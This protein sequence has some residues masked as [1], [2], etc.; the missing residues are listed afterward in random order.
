MA[1]GSRFKPFLVSADCPRGRFYAA[2]TV[3]F[4]IVALA[5]FF[6]FIFNGR[7]FV[8]VDT[9]DGGD[10]LVQHFNA[11]CYYGMWLRDIARNLLFEHSLVVPMWDMS[12]GYG[13]DVIT[14][15]SYYVIGDP[16]S[17]LSV[18]IPRRFA[19]AGYCALIVLRMY[20]AGVAFCMFCRSRN[21]DTH[22]TLIGSI[23]YVF[24]FYALS[25]GVLHPY[26]LLP[27]IWLPLLLMGV[28]KILDDKSGLQYALVYALAG[29]SNFYF[30]YMLTIIVLLYAIARYAKLYGSVFPVKRLLKHIARMLVYSLLGAGAAAVLLLPSMMGILSA[31][32]VN[33]ENYVP[34]LYG[35]HHYVRG[36][37]A[38]I[39]GGYGSYTYL[40]FTVVGWVSTCLLI[41]RYKQSRDHK[42]LVASFLVLMLFLG[43]PFV[44]HVFNGFG[45]VTN[46]WVWALA[47][48]VAYIVAF[49]VPHLGEITQS[50]RKAILIISAVA[51]L[52]VLAVPDIC[53]EKN[54]LAFGMLFFL[55]A[56]MFYLLDADSAKR[57]MTKLLY[58]IVAVGVASNA[59]YLY[60]P[61]EENYLKNYAQFGQALKMLI[62]ESPGYV[63]EDVSDEELF[64]YDCAGLNVGEVRRNSAMQL[65]LNG[66]AYYFSTTNSAVSAFAR[67]LE[68][69]YSMDQTYNDL[70]RRTVLDRIACVRYM[71]TT[72]DREKYLPLGYEHKALEGKRFNAYEGSN[73]LSFGFATDKV[74]STS[75]FE[76]ANV[77][78]KERLLSTGIVYDGAE[79]N[80]GLGSSRE[81]TLDYKV[82]CG[83]G[84][85]VDDDGNIV[86]DKD[87]STVKLSFGPIEGREL[88]VEFN[89]LD[90]S[91]EGPLSDANAENGGVKETLARFADALRWKEPT[92][93][94][95]GLSD[96]NITT[97][98]QYRTMK[99]NYYCGRDTFIA[100]L[101][102]SADKRSEVTMKFNRAGTYSFDSIFLYAPS[103]AT[104][105]EDIANLNAIHMENVSM[106][107]NGISGSISLP[108]EGVLCMQIPY[109]SGWTARIDGEKAS[110]DQADVMFVGMKV[111]A[112]SH[113]IQ[114][115]Y[116]T[117]YLFEGAAISIVSLV[118]LALATVMCRV[119][120]SR[121]RNHE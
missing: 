71:L 11:F 3:L 48:L 112:G 30:F 85:Y 26:F 113:E 92:S 55:L 78:D 91:C 62:N 102:L 70:D 104:L 25:S 40:G 28:D 76:E 67:E 53:T 119:R 94:D 43:L 13:Q 56:V 63:L 81:P 41:L 121:E 32:R 36:I 75:T 12:I 34:L 47:F 64:R 29:I 105:D 98:V 77:V 50:E 65:D 96:G 80:L 5:V 14:T 38:F 69:N 42:F 20:C 107:P 31:S 18:A 35:L 79:E 7:S 74:V 103:R 117:P 6:P 1:F 97:N 8:F 2:Y 120:G 110:L 72:P 60:S 100:N 37:P 111:P 84:A 89:K 19:E 83:E 17:F 93:V 39:N 59:F 15:L 44:G 116:R 86:I 22:G 99:D 109:S 57:H 118:G 24:C 68:L 108:K 21:L 49:M 46:R 10:G 95:I 106:V 4:A 61:S 82:E 90:Y 73:V 88:Y 33:V 52:I 101:G 23:V 115:T 9:S 45:Y 87:G 27:M 51:A 114:L 58:V 16:F 54:V 66:I